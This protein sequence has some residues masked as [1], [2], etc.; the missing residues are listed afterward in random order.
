MAHLMLKSVENVNT[1]VTFFI[2]GFHIGKC[3]ILI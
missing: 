1:A 2:L 3:E